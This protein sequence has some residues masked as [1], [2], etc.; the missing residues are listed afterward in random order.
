MAD[1]E[2]ELDIFGEEGGE[3]DGDSAVWDMLTPQQKKY[4]KK[5]SEKSPENMSY[6]G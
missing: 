6:I 2:K 4:F 1:E 3:M 5:L